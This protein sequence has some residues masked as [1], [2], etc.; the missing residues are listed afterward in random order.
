MRA[1][2]GKMYVI[3]VHVICI[4]T[5]ITHAPVFVIKTVHL[6]NLVKR[7]ILLAVG[8]SLF[9][10]M[11]APCAPGFVVPQYDYEWGTELPH[12]SVGVAVSGN[13]LVPAL[14]VLT[15][16]TLCIFDTIR[17]ALVM[18]ESWYTDKNQLDM[19]W[20]LMSCFSV[21]LLFA[22]TGLLLGQ[23]DM[24]MLAVIVFMVVF[25]G[26]CGNILEQ[27]RTFINP[28]TVP[29]MSGTVVQLLRGLQDT[30]L[31]VAAQLISIPFIYNSISTEGSVT[32]TQTLT[33][34]LHCFL[35]M[36]ITFSHYR[37]DRLS[38]DFE[39]VWM[40]SQST[41]GWS[42]NPREVVET[43][44]T[45]PIVR[46]SRSNAVRVEKLKPI[47]GRSHGLKSME[48]V[49]VEEDLDLAL[50]D[51]TG[52]MM[53]EFHTMYGWTPYKEKSIDVARVVEPDEYML[54]RSVAM[55]G[56]LLEW[57]R[58]YLINLFINTLLVINLVSMTG[59][60]SDECANV[61]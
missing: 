52:D 54:E 39:Q 32:Q 41:I 3:S 42:V 36:A 60:V 61:L 10:I 47:S 2:L 6:V 16:S 8:I 22:S 57:R 12:A 20:L 50:Q 44:T 21:P 11:G 28:R 24:L 38:S 33:A 25:S 55:I 27:L 40:D 17:C 18:A 29:G 5:G 53:D 23:H 1:C 49:R 56:Q 43:A 58:Y 37:H 48:R 4:A 46:L 59:V 30:S 45:I 31:I 7:I 9:A 51:E 15:V 35:V 26:V 34:F 14:W 19:T 13:A